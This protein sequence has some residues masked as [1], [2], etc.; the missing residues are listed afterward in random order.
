[1]TLQLHEAPFLAEARQ[2]EL[3]FFQDR[4]VRAGKPLSMLPFPKC[5][6]AVVVHTHP[7][8]DAKQGSDTRIFQV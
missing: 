1:M 4:L 7:A 5:R 2:L 3:H 8:S 6:R